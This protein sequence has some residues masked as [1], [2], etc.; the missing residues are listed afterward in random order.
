MACCLVAQV[1]IVRSVLA[2]R[3]CPPCGRSCRGRAGPCEVMWAIVP[4][5]AL[6]VLLFFT[7]RAMRRRHHDARR[8]PRG[9]GA[10]K[11]VRRFA[12]ATFVVACLHL[13][14]GAIVRISGSG[15]GCGDHWPKCYG[16]WFPP[17]NR[18]DLIVEVI[19]PLSRVDLA[20]RA[21]RDAASSR[22]AV[23][24]SRASADAG[25][26]CASARLAVALGSPRRCSARVT[27]KLGNAPFATRRA[28]DCRDEPRR[29]AVATLIRAGGLGGDACASSAAC[30]ARRAR[31]VRAARRWRFS[32]S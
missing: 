18:P 17:L 4:A 9:S 3:A 21:H 5:V 28:L 30:R 10:M 29:D 25:A 11:T 13:V 22:G 16:H 6:A 7:W 19:A 2:A 15:M 12:T 1:L 26:C 32:P 31:R 8:D 24:T 27:V 14:F 23:A 20:A